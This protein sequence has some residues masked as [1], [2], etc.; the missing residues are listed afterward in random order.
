[1]T[2]KTDI[3]DTLRAE[4][5]DER[6]EQLERILVMLDAFDVATEARDA[7]RGQALDAIWRVIETTR[8]VLDGR[9]WRGLPNLATGSN[10]LHAVNVR[11]P[12]PDERLDKPRGRDTLGKERLVLTD[13]CE[14]VSAWMI[15]PV[16]AKICPRTRK[17]TSEDLRAEDAQL[18]AAAVATAI[19]FHLVAAGKQGRRWEELRRLAF[20]LRAATV[21]PT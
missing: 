13:F 19:D 21:E 3:P 1:M 6:A 11:G 17:A 9:R 16:G 20:R 12:H 18:V 14:L 10:P 4:L 8:E 7:A 15:R 5:G 2:T